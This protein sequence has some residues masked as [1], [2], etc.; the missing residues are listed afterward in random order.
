MTKSKSK[1]MTMKLR[2][3]SILLL[4]TPFLIESCKK[5]SP[6]PTPDF[7]YSGVGIAPA[8]V[9]FFNVSTN[10]TSYSWDF[11]DNGT[12]TQESPTHTYLQGGVYTVK[13]TVMGPGGTNS[14]TKTVNIQAPT[15]VK[16]T[17]VKI[18]A[19]PFTKSTG[20]GW[21]SN[22]GPDVY[23]AIE[24]QNG[25]I[26]YTSTTY[27]NVG[28]GNL[29]VSFNINPAF[30]TGNLSTQY[31]VILWDNDTDELFSTS[32]EWIGGYIF[33]FS[34]FASQG[35]PSTVTL[36]TASSPIKIE[37]TLQWQ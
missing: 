19:M 18:T 17:S 29:P 35:Y 11:G 27:P 14:T 3:L 31:Q 23:Y 28:A 1:H 2:Y 34:Q 16:I 10:A 20:G 4:A 36:Q 15:S 33:S 6:A 5:D 25:S 22:S 7:T 30:Q 24:S 12:S 26:L 21:D 32:D 37:L 13:L 9:T 8:T